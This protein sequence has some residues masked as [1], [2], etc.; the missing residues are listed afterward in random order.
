MKEDQEDNQSTFDQAHE[1][2]DDSTEIESELSEE[3]QS[4]KDS[5]EDAE[6]PKLYAGKF[7]SPE[8]MELAYQEIQR[9]VGGRKEIEAKA[10]QYDRMVTKQNAEAAA[11]SNTPMPKLSNYVSKEDGGID[12]VK[13]DEAIEA[14][15]ADQAKAAQYHASIRSQEDSDIQRSYAD[16]PY[17][18]NDPDAAET[19][20]AFYQSGRAGSIYEAAQRLDAKRGNDKDKVVTNAKVEVAHELSKRSRGNTERA[21]ANSRRDSGEMTEAK[22]E[23]MSLEE[24]AKYINKQ[25]KSG[26]WKF[27]DVR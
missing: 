12:V 25:F 4:A 24:R 7:K 23:S 2:Q 27:D 19:V 6:Q 16:F 9:F 5:E 8:E 11:R 13:Y 26:A 18:R 21:N 15:H 22:I 3:E 20:M 1:E 17:L 14:W 10:A